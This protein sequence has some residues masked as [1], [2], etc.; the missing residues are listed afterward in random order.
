[1]KINY[2]F[3]FII[4]ITSCVSNTKKDGNLVFINLNAVSGTINYNGPNIIYSS[5]DTSVC[6]YNLEKKI[7]IFK[8]KLKS[9]SYAQ[10]LIRDG[11]IYVPISDEKFC[12]FDQSKKKTIWEKPLEGKCSRF[13]FID[14]TNIIASVKGY[15]LIVFNSQNGNSLYELLYR[16][17]QTQLPDDSP[18]R[19]IFDRNNLY[20]S[21]WQGNY[22]SCFNK[23]EGKLKWNFNIGNHGSSGQAVDAGKDIF[24]GI[25][26]F[27]KGGKIVL[28]NKNTGKAT[29]EKGTNFEEN[30]IPI[31]YKNNIYFYC[32]DSNLNIFDLQ[33]KSIK[34]ILSFNKDNDIEVGQMFLENDIYFNDCS[35]LI[36][37]L[38]LTDNRKTPIRKLNT[39]V[40]GIHNWNDKTFFISD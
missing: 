24:L 9:V 31:R 20:V 40:I 5:W 27:Y 19:L 7:I 14:D 18:W 39:V 35:F 25:N 8:K 23:K 36:N 32:Y 34:N 33:S 28:I 30:M 13:E 15:G 1:M 6:I 11:R 10:P 38:S 29:F 22:L 21:N 2:I 17:K 16:Y 4:I 12:C 3:I 37:K 26:Y